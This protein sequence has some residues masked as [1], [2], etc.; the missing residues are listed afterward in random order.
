[1]ISIKEKSDYYKKDRKINVI[2]IQKP[3]L[4]N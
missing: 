3:L 1:M 4:V 2:I